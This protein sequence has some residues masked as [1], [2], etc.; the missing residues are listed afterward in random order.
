MDPL[1]ALSLAAA[2]L[3]FVEAGS[4][5]VKR[6][7]EFTADLDDIPRSFRQVRTELPL[8]IDGLRRINE[9]VE[10]GLVE[11]STEAA[12]LPVVRECLQ[13]AIELNNLLD[14]IIPPA[15]ASSWERR[16]KAIASLSKDKKVDELARALEKYVRILT[17]HQVTSAPAKTSRACF[18]FVPFDR[19]PAFVGRDAVFQAVDQ[20]FNVRTVGSQPKVSLCGLGGIGKSQIALEYC[21]RKRLVDNQVSVFWV[22]AATAPRFEESF[23][24][25]AN[26]CG[27]VGHNDA[28]TDGVLRAQQWLQAQD[29]RWIMVIDNVD[30]QSGYFREKISNGKTPSQCTPRCPNG[31]LIFTTRT[32]DMA[33]D[34]AAPAAPVMVAEL[35]E[36]EG[37][38]LVRARLDGRPPVDDDVVRQ[39]LTELEY[40]PLAITQALAFM[41]KRRKSIPQ[42]L[43][44][45]RKS[46]GN[47]SRLLSFDFADHGRQDG[48]LESVAR[49]WSISFESIRENNP[50][51]ANLLCIMSFFQHQSI[52]LLL[53][54][55]ADDGEE[56]GVENAWDIL[57][58][59]SL[60]NADEDQKT[61]H[62]HRLVQLATGLWLKRD[63]PNEANRWATRA[64]CSLGHHFP[65]TE[66]NHQPIGDYWLRCQSL[67]PHVDL[68]L[69]HSFEDMPK[70]RQKDIDLKR[71]RLLERSAQ[72]FISVGA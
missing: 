16:K 40:I 41:S 50:R 10:A 5:I 61:F 66:L 37:L 18:W 42:Y 45:Y 28:A 72:Y 27:L 70:G 26:E 39:L 21:Y 15:T 6:L 53:L 17:F 69:K 12:L 31:T 35:D 44:L 30:D 58:D 24:R 54:Q 13:S 47:K 34:L 63:G 51:T 11:S 19:N 14:R 23:K 22:N 57:C 38:Q 2:I 33:V 64:L 43:E 25:I 29:F 48:S 55:D 4:K 9:Q 7:S 68:L 49:T 65:N 36:K 60:L 32:R 71:A 67:L 1:T 8:I 59:Y 52:P 20:A 62:T 46:D 3:Q 56:D